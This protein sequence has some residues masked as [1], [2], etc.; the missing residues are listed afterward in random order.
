MKQRGRK[1]ADALSMVV[2][3]P[4]VIPGERPE[5]PKHLTDEQAETWRAAVGRMPAD[6]FTPEIWPL[7][8]QLCRHVSISRMVA[9]AL[10]EVDPES[11]RDARGFR[12]FERLRSMHDRETRAIVALMRTLRITHQSQYDQTRA[13]TARQNTPAKK[14]WE[15]D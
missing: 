5:P 10:A 15:C 12:R 9:E 3:L 11:M 6:W 2:S 13:F 4:G 14:P 7:L 1:S 8:T